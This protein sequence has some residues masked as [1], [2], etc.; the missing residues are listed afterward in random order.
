MAVP[1]TPPLPAAKSLLLPQPWPSREACPLGWGQLAACV[2]FQRVPACL[3]GSC[4]VLHQPACALFAALPPSWDVSAAPELLGKAELLHFQHC[5][6]WQRDVNK[7]MQG[8]SGRVEGPSLA[9][10]LM[11]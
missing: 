2:H 1:F 10:N 7:A 11:P 9:L 3:Q 6:G 8:H 5:S 4:P